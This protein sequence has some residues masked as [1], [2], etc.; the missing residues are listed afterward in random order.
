MEVLMFYFDILSINR[1]I[2]KLK[3]TGYPTTYINKLG[4]KLPCQNSCCKLHLGFV[5]IL[6]AYFTKSFN[7]KYK[8]KLFTYL[9]NA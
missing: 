8:Y 5:I 4:P 1:I 6:V 7:I 2:Y 9:I 3:Y